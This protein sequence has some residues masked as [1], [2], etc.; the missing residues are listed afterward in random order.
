MTAPPESVPTTLATA[1][2]DRYA[3]ERELGRGGMARVYL[4]RDIRHD[5][6]VAIKVMD[7]QLS[8]MIGAERFLRE[9]R[10]TAQLTHPN[11]I[12]LIDSG[13]TQGL[14]YYV[15]PYAP[16]E[17]LRSRLMRESQLPMRDALRIAR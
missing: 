5:R 12:P 3:I 6:D 17:S 9:I 15:T 14:L 11:I 7:P 16:D 13:Q 10:V 2:V 4:A 1:L 8:A